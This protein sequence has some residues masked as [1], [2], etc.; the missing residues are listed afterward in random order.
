MTASCL[1]DGWW[2]IL[3]EKERCFCFLCLPCI[4]TWHI[5]ACGCFLHPLKKNYCSHIFEPC[6]SRNIDFCRTCSLEQLLANR[7]KDTTAPGVSPCETDQ[8]T[9]AHAE[10]GAPLIHTS[11]GLSKL[12]CW[13]QIFVCKS[14]MVF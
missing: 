14:I 1:E 8:Y 13:G 4:P 7:S 9:Q 5:P 3:T 2:E 6:S 10:E 12:C 11:K